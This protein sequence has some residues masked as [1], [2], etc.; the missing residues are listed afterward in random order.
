MRGQINIFPPKISLYN[1]WRLNDNG[2]I[3]ISYWALLGGITSN[4]LMNRHMMSYMDNNEKNKKKSPSNQK[5]QGN[6]SWSNPNAGKSSQV[7][8][9]QKPRDQ[10][11]KKK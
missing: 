7:R 11:S 4:N 8:T 2:A 1:N 3:V 10:Q 9:Q 5:P 6:S